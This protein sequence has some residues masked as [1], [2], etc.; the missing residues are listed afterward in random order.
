MKTLARLA[1]LFLPFLFF[2]QFFSHKAQAFSEIATAASY[3]IMMDMETGTVLLEHNA[4][5]LMP[6]ASMTKIVTLALLFQALKENRVRLEDQFIVSKN[7]VEKGGE[8][9]GSSSMFL[10][11]ESLVPVEDLIKGIVVQSGNDAAITVA[12]NLAVSEEA[13]A[14]QMTEFAKSIGMTKT[15]FKNATGWPEEGH[16]TTAHDLAILTRHHIANYSEF[17]HYYA[18]R[19]FTWNKITQ[20]NRNLLLRD[21]IGVDGLKTGHTEESGYGIVASAKRGKRRLILVLNGLRSQQERRGEGYKIFNWGFRSFQTYRFFKAGDAIEKI[22]VWHGVKNKI[23]AVVKEDFAIAITRARRRLVRVSIDYLTPIPAPIKKGDK[24][25]WV[26]IKELG[27]NVIAE[28]PLVAG[29]DIERLGFLGRAVSTLEYL[30]F[31]V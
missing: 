3:A 13:F 14:K 10:E 7:A 30:L 16:E 12:E 15:T 11:P 22:A 5:T 2:T 21:R 24:I 26:R 4:D 29:Q 28:K 9:S 23:D 19:S 27:G 8:K 17:Y 31:G 1:L 20:S 25:G 6:P 18:K